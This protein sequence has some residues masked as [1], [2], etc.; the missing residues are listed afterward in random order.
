MDRLIISKT[1][2][3]D[4]GPEMTVTGERASACGDWVRAPVFRVGGMWRTHVTFVGFLALKNK[5]I[6]R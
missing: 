5:Q 6:L 1:P 3:K 4:K 2:L